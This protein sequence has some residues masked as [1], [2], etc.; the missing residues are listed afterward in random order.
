MNE[1]W[2]ILV[3][4]HD[5]DDEGWQFV[6]GHGDTDDAKNGMLTNDL[7]AEASRALDET[8][9]EFLPDWEEIENETNGGRGAAGEY[10]RALRE[11]VQTAG[12]ELMGALAANHVARQEPR[13][14]IPLLEQALERQPD[15]EDL[16]RKLRAAYLETGQHARA[17][18]LQ[19]DYAL[20]T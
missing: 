1:G 18:E 9:G 20:D 13:K 4:T 5:L 17:T 15:R 14:A 6:N 16:A 2:P 19:K 11:L 10:V 8:E 7:A 12:V 3:V